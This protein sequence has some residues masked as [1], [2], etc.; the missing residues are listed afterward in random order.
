MPSAQELIAHNRTEQEIAE[1]IGADCL[2]YQDLED[3]VESAKEGNSDITQFDCA[4]FDNIYVTGDVDDVYLQKLEANRND[5]AKNGEGSAKNS[6]L[7]EVIGLHNS[8][9]EI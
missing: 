6:A 7:D 2:I 5:S 3:L 9:P 4:V 1:L 8:D